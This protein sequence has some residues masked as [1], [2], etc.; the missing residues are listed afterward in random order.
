M[1]GTTKAPRRSKDQDR[2]TDRQTDG[3]TDRQTDRQTDRRALKADNSPRKIRITTQQENS[4]DKNNSLPTLSTPGPHLRS[5][6]RLLVS[7]APNL[8]TKQR[9]LFRNFTPKDLHPLLP[10]DTSNHEV[11]TRSLRTQRARNASRAIPL[12]TFANVKNPSI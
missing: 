6:K 4:Q 8:A 9:N 1:K 10:T 12:L 11:R 7:L 3:R 2:Q 5:P